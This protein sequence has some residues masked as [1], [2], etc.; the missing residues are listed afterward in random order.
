MKPRA[1]NTVTAPR[2]AFP[3]NFTI[4]ANYADYV[5]WVNRVKKQTSI[6][7]LHEAI[8]NTSIPAIEKTSRNVAQ[9]PPLRPHIAVL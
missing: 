3:F 5:V 6:H 1:V 4:L 9:T 8:L 2:R 7:L